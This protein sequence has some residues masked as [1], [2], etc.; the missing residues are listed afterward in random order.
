[1]Q[2]RPRMHLNLQSQTRKSTRGERVFTEIPIN[3]SRPVCNDCLI[4]C[5]QVE[6]HLYKDSRINHIQG[7][8]REGGLKV[9]PIKGVPAY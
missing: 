4:L 1:M 7:A 6:S 9:N 8:V 5:K 3:N 2:Y